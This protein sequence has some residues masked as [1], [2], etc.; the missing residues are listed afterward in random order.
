MLTWTLEG[1]TVI[2]VIYICVDYDRRRKLGYHRGGEEGLDGELTVDERR[3]LATLIRSLGAI[4][5]PFVLLRILVSRSDASCP[6]L[7]V[8]MMWNFGLWALDMH[9]VHG[10]RSS[11]G[12]S[13]IASLRFDPA[14]VS[15]LAFGLCGLLGGGNVNAN[16]LHLFLCSIVGCLVFVMPSHNMKPMCIEQQIFE[17]VQKTA[18][19]WCTGTLIAAVVLC[20]CRQTTRV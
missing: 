12:S 20:R 14:I 6:Q 16:H 13:E 1:A 8:P 2:G 3:D 17:N 7:V 18:L 19:V 11:A 15:P 4:L 5:W 9:L 10:T